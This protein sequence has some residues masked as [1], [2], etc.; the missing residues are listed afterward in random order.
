MRVEREVGCLNDIKFRCSHEIANLKVL[1]KRPIHN[2]HH[3]RPYCCNN[4]AEALKKT[5]AA[6]IIAILMDLQWAGTAG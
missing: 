6:K 3:L 4:A 1:P 2:V 5:L